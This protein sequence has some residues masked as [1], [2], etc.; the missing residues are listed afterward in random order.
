MSERPGVQPDSGVGEV[1]GP[2]TTNSYPA[3]LECDVI[4]SSGLTLRLRPIQPKDAEGLIRFHNKLSSD[5]VYRRYFSMHPEL[6]APEVDH[7]T[8]VD[9]TDRLAF[10]VEDRD[11][12]VAVGRYDRQPNTPT[13]E[14]AFLVSDHYQQHGIGQLLLE[15]LADAAW[16]R[17]ITE[18][19]AETQADNRGMMRVFRESGFDVTSSL[20]DG[21]ISVRFPIEPTETS[22]ARRAERRTRALLNVSTLTRRG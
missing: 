9:Y 6:S 12:M 16:E 21:V 1:H 4:T 11:E 10:V 22:E 3:D 7:L 17:G 15:H 20:E 14:V 8:T 18:F 13:A 5:S 19:C 2:A